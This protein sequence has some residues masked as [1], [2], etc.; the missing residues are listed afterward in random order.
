MNTE[1]EI[2]QLKL[3]INK[4][5]SNLRDLTIKF[6]E[7]K[8]QLPTSTDNGLPTPKADIVNKIESSKSNIEINTQKFRGSSNP[9]KQNITDD[10]LY[11]L[12]ELL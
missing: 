4:L 11:K 5:K 9:Y 6:K 1:E 8:S 12:A 10:E 2:N 3:E 7:L